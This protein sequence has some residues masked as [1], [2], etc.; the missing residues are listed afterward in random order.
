MHVLDLSQVLSPGSA[1]RFE[2]K[3][4]ARALRWSSNGQELYLLIHES[5]TLDH[6]HRIDA[7]NPETG[8]FRT[9]LALRDRG[10]EDDD[11]VESDF[12]VAPYG[13]SESE[14]DRVYFRLGTGEWYSVEGKRARVRPEAGKPAGALPASATPDGKLRLDRD[15]EDGDSWLDLETE[16]ETFRV[17]DDDAQDDGALWAQEK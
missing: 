3:R 8:A 6:V 17:T 4:P 16:S 9:V 15:S 12:W 13:E 1:R 11:I 14:V 10:L 5:G 2:L 7:L